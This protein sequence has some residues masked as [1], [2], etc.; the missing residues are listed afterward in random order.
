MG[1]K[2]LLHATCAP[3]NAAAHIV[4][5]GSKFGNNRTPDNYENNY[6]N[7]YF[8]TKPSPTT[9]IT[10]M[11]L[12]VLAVLLA[13]R[14]KSNGNIDPVQLILAILFSISIA[15]MVLVLWTY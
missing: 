1:V 15:P 11:L 12:L 8:F 9:S 3:V 10:S 6:E 5:S 7:N 4:S 14:C 13:L 2:E